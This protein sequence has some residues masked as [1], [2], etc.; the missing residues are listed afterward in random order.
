MKK[1][2]LFIISVMLVLIIGMAAAPAR[3][4]QA[5]ESI[6]VGDCVTFGRY[7]QTISGMDYTPI[8][9]QVLDVREDKVLLLSRYAL[10][11]QPY[12]GEKAA[13][14]WGY[15]T[16]RS[17]LNE[18]F[19]EQAFT[20]AEEKSILITEV[21]NDSSQGHPGYSIY[22]GDNTQD[23]VFLLSYA[24]S[25]TYF[26][27]DDARICIPTDYAIRQSV[28]VQNNKDAIGMWICDW[29]L[30]SPGDSL[31][32]ATFVDIDPTS[33]SISL[34]HN[35]GVRPA[36]WV[37]MDA[38]QSA[39]DTPK[40]NAEKMIADRE[41]FTKEGNIVIFGHYEQDNDPYNGKEPVE[42][43]VLKYDSENEKSLLLSL[44]CLDAHRFDV[45][46]YQ[47]WDKSEMRRLLNS[48]FLDSAFTNAERKA[49]ATTTVTTQGNDKWVTN[50]IQKGREYASLSGGADSRD[51]VFLLS[52]EEVMEYG[53]C[54]AVEDVIGGDM[55][56]SPTEF[57]LAN[58][59][60]PESFED[61]NGEWWC[62]W[63]LRSPGYKSQSTSEVYPLDRSSGWFMS[64]DVK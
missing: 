46:E 32:Q 34:G 55:I 28:T 24:E 62:S 5:R 40:D 43:I 58:G 38:F 51:S 41:P 48:T 26:D 63:A 31:L 50:A 52:L 3:N 9:W 16:L 33:I 22:G 37:E 42:W 19:L 44:H 7:P 4:A 59:A 56:A 60:R 11:C 54:S 21:V 53:E 47:G 36:M 14:A 61:E 18:R 45:N 17:W 6:A 20:S 27:S 49:I 23:K 35:G 2:A 64:V 1:S 29:W 10:D 39:N 8:E 15:C 30:R 13:A 12:D 25:R 57:A